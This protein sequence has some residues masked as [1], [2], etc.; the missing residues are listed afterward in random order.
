MS[1]F[2]MMGTLVT[3]VVGGGGYMSWDHFLLRFTRVFIG[4]GGAI[5]LK[6]VGI[7]KVL[8]IMS[9]WCA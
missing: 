6:I 3:S 5:V 1:W 9:I 2:M 4:V 8:Q 7:Y